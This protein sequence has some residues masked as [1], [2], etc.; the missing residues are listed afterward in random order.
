MVDH[1]ETG[2]VAYEAEVFGRGGSA[3]RYVM[4][5]GTDSASLLFFDP[6]A[7]PADFER[8]FQRDSVEAL[9]RLAGDGS[10]CWINTGADGTYLLH[11]YV[12]EPFPA[13][14][15]GHLREPRSIAEFRVPSGLLVLAGAEHAS[16]D[17]QGS[18]RKQTVEA[19]SISIRPGVYRLIVYRAA[20]PAKVLDDRFRSAILPWEWLLWHSMTLLIP[21]AIAAWIGLV[22]IFFTNVRVPFPSYLAPVL[23]LVFALP[24]VVRR[25]EAYASVK[26][27][28]ASLVREYPPLAARLEFLGPDSR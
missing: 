15:W 19:D 18:A 26:A 20:Y 3:M 24:F 7:L 10:A 8:R 5:A 17:D 22:V 14:L 13:D 21:L 25:T 1:A 16:R 27:R 11:A 9:E 6:A 23:G 28:Y 2:G 12:N 4:E